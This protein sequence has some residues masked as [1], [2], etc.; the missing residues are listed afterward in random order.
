MPPTAPFPVSGGLTKSPLHRVVRNG[1]RGPSGRFREK[2]IAVLAW[3]FLPKPETHLARTF[4]DGEFLKQW[5][6]ADLR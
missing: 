6:A 5:V 2:Q 1:L 4:P 3:S